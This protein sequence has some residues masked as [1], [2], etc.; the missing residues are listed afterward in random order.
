MSASTSPSHYTEDAFVTDAN[1]KVEINQKMKVPDK[2]S[3]N[4]DLNGA[5]QPAWNRDNINMQVPERILVVG[6]HQHIE[7]YPGDVRVATPPRTL[8]LDKYPFPTLEEMEDPE[9]NQ[10]PV[11][12]PKKKQTFDDSDLNLT[13]RET[14]PPIGGSGE[15]LTPAEE[16][17]HLRR[18]MAKLNRRVMALELENLSRLQ[19]EKF[20]VGFGV[21][22]LLLK[23][24]IWMNRE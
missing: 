5:T 18:Q 24:I 22:Y 2:I 21:A 14:T 17:L 1:F 12:K 19:K 3:F 4:T 11:V 20:L 13:I 23:V 9:L 7:P 10:I 8:T 6:Q 16:V 15:R